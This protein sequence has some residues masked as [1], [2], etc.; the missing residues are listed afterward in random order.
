MLDKS[1][2]RLVDDIA[3]VGWHLIGVDRD[4]DRP[5]FVYS[6]G[7][8]V[9]FDHPEVI[10]FGLDVRLMADVINTM[11]REIRSGRT[12]IEPVLYTGLIERYA[13]K[14][15]PVARR[16]H[17][18]YFGYALWHRRHIGKTG[19]L[20]AIQCFWPDKAGLFPDDIGCHPA[21]LELQPRL[22]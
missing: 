3:R 18:D 21:I 13:C 19:T 7:L 17:E 12:F 11:G 6:I 10:M 8:M 9:T 4:A 14:T 5:S 2:Q 15:A 1:E 22:Q 16:F 20:E